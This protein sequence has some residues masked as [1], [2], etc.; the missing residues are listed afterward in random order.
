[1]LVVA[2]EPIL[3]VLSRPDMIWQRMHKLG[4]WMMLRVPDWRLEG[5][6][7]LELHIKDDD[8]GC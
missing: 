7:Y 8:G 2:K 4:A 5:W 3:K 6:G 1:M